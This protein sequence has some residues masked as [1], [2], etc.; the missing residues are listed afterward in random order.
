MPSVQKMSFTAIGAPASLP[1]PAPPSS[2]SVRHRKAFSSSPAAALV[3]APQYSSGESSP[4]SMRRSASPT[5]RSRSSLIITLDQ[6]DASQ[7]AFGLCSAP[8]CLGGGDAEGSLG[9]VRSLGEDAF[10]R[11]ARPRL[12]GGGHVFQSDPG[13]GRA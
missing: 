10:P 4:P 2:D 1:S 9:G 8:S 13:G 7:S 3:H 11:P 5:V 6:P 12:V